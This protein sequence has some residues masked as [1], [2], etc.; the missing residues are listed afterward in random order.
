MCKYQLSTGNVIT[1]Y[2][3]HELIQKIKIEKRHF[4]LMVLEA[5]K[6]K[7]KTTAGSVPCA[8]RIL[9][10]D[11]HPPALTSHGREGEGDLWGRAHTAT[12]L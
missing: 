6:S 3:K 5:E 4:S 11:G 12:H 1:M 10:L 2:C 9:L 8:G 7:S